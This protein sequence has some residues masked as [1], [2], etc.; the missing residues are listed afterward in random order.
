MNAVAFT[1]AN[2]VARGTGWSMHGWG[3]GDRATNEA[4]APLETYDERLDA[5]LDDV[6]EL[7]FEAIDLW[8]AHL[9]PEWATDDHVA[10]A[11]DALAR[12]GIE[13]TTYAAWVGPG[14]V[15]RCAE[16]ALALGTDL[17]GA[18][19]SGDPAAIGASA[20]RHGV[21][22][23]IENHPE[24]SP[25]EVLDK[26]E[27]ADGG[28]AAT[29]DTGWWATHGFDPVTAI[30]EL[31]PHVRHVHLKDVLRAGEPHETCPWGKGI[32]DVHGCVSALR[33]MGYTGA[34]TVEHEP[35]DHD[36]SPDLRAMRE[37]LEGWLA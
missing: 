34:L 35:E 2:F 15:D 24:R 6:R 32:V 8:G 21:T 18:G 22:V 12:H 23:A 13:V 36:P 30:E 3:H 29:V 27:A 20:L 37:R 1:T 31:A 33:G 16:L 4:F 11:R 9:A 10:I 17:I 25:R 14:N 5:L 28:L 26:I 19:I 7:G